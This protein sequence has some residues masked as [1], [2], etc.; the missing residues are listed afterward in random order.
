[1]T[2]ILPP[3]EPWINP[4]IGMIEWLRDCRRFFL[5]RREGRGEWEQVPAMS[6]HRPFVSIHESKAGF[7][8]I[9]HWVSPVFR[10]LLPVEFEIWL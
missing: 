1:L 2:V 7:F 4:T 8:P 3:P 5:S 6:D 10:Y 9:S